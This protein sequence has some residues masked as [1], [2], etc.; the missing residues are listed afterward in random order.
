MTKKLTEEFYLVSNYMI[1]DFDKLQMYY[2]V[3]KF[4]FKCILQLYNKCQKFPLKC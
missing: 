3:E 1:S 4:K 2:N